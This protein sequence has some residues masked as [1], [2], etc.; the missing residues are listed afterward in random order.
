MFEIFYGCMFS[1]KSGDML[2]RVLKE[3]KYA[4]KKVVFF[5][6]EV[7]TR[8]STT[9]ASRIGLSAE[10]FNIPVD[11]SKLIET[12]KSSGMLGEIQVTDVSGY[13]RRR[14]FDIVAFDEA[15]FFSPE[16]VQLVKLLLNDD[17]D[18]MAA[19]LNLDYLQKPIGSVGELILMADEAVHKTA[20]CSVCGEKA[21]FSQRV[22]NGQEVTASNNPS[23]VE[24][25]DSES[26]E[27][28]CRKHFRTVDFPFGCGN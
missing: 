26:Y 3:E 12:Y 7:D 8:T 15:Q 22:V 2:S 17:I 25:G 21:L 23:M 4:K 20:Y 9:V 10:A 28:R 19:A 11:A 1:E 27:P 5:K 14:R 18:V 6:P 24:I 16:I 13:R